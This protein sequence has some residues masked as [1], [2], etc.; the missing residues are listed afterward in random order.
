MCF[1]GFF[2]YNFTLAFIV[3]AIPF[4]SQPVY[5]FNVVKTAEGCTKA[6][7]S[8]EIIGT[9]PNDVIVI[10]WS[11]G[12]K[13]V[14]ELN[15]L[16]AGDYSAYIS[17]LHTDTIAHFKDTIINFKIEKVECAV[18]VAKYFSPNGDGYNDKLGIE[19]I[20]LYPDFELEVFSKFG[21]KVYTQKK[22]YIPWDGKWQGID[23]PDGT[24]YFV[25]F[26]NADDKNNL[27]KG[28]ITILR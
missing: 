4:F 17:I 9:T 24:Y 20:D 26:Y 27:V 3:F 25:L 19:H 13:N 10:N 12:Q 6:K 2:R 22:N 1:K 14:R 5:Q 28:D 11:S 23:L 8:L 7:A 21:Q 16:I 18:M 15:D